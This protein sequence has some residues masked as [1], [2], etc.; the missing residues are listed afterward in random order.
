[1][2][3]QFPFPYVGPEIK[4]Y[5]ETEIPDVKEITYG[6]LL[7]DT[8]DEVPDAVKVGNNYVPKDDLR[9]FFAFVGDVNDFLNIPLDKGLNL[10]IEK[11]KG[12]TE[13]FKML[14]K[15]NNPK[16]S[17]PEQKDALYRTVEGLVR[18]H[19]VIVRYVGGEGIADAIKRKQL[20][21]IKQFVNYYPGFATTWLETSVIQGVSSEHPDFI[22]FNPLHWAMYYRAAYPESEE[23]DK[24]CAFLMERTEDQYK[25]MKP[26]QS[27][28][29]MY[30]AIR[31]LQRLVENESGGVVGLQKLIR[32]G[33]SPI[34]PSMTQSISD[35][36]T[37]RINS[38]EIKIGEL[39]NTLNMFM[40]KLTLTEES[41]KD[42]IGDPERRL[43]RT[44]KN[45]VES[46]E[47]IHG[48]GDVSL[49]ITD[50]GD[51][52]ISFKVSRTTMLGSIL[53][54][55]IE[56]TGKGGAEVVFRLME[57]DQLTVYINRSDTLEKL[58]VS[59]K[60]VLIWVFPVV[61]TEPEVNEVGV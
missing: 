42:R 11:I 19:P 33:W 16:K 13:L 41:I 12:P 18:K 34:L 6:E 26:L 5:L 8:Y 17:T 21:L 37:N 32:N 55:Y 44:L 10:N 23:L 39:T 29:Y 49:C 20:R 51:N 48:E 59:S 53:D 40:Q 9:D 28:T 57:G 54:E 14:L 38:L 2:I 27:G 56:R 4:E 36:E 46:L 60:K 61:K 43:I 50:G 15:F 45:T 7:G 31:A 1:M 58:K 52:D 22:G 25:E 35:I 24:I 47:T 3:A 30:R